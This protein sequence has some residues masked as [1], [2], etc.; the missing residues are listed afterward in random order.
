MVDYLSKASKM[1]KK[2]YRKKYTLS[3]SKNKVN[4]TRKYKNKSQKSRKSH[5]SRRSVRKNTVNVRR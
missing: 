5:T 4:K 3:K 2:Y 1:I